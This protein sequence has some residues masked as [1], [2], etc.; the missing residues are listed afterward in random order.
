VK[1]LGLIGF[2]NEL[3]LGC[4][5]ETLGELC[6]LFTAHKKDWVDAL[7]KDRYN[8]IYKRFGRLLSEK[9]KHTPIRE[10]ISS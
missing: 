8:Q 1:Q 6:V 10:L 9:E 7:G 2:E 3:V 4:G 5:C